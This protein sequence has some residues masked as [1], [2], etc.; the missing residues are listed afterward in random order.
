MKSAEE[1]KVMT[2]KS[3]EDLLKEKGD[4]DIIE[5]SISK[6][7]SNGEFSCEI[8]YDSLKVHFDYTKQY[9]E[10]FGYDLDEIEK[11]TKIPPFAADP[12][13]FAHAKKFLVI[14]W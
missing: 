9:L 8:D 3:I 11:E 4:Y 1:I 10:N 12:L 6:A 14:K 2:I 5:K 13:G 7:A